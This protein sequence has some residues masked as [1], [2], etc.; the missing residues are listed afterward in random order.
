VEA[1]SAKAIIH[2]PFLRHADSDHNKRSQLGKSLSFVDFARIDFMNVYLRR[3]PSTQNIRAASL[4]LQAVVLNRANNL[5]IRSPASSNTTTSIETLRQR[6]RLN[7]SS[8]NL[9]V[10]PRLA[11]KRWD[12]RSLVASQSHSKRHT[13]LTRAICLETT[14]EYRSKTTSLPSR[15][16]RHKILSRESK[17]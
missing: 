14:K 16:A 8:G 13:R 1:V 5:G 6:R 11:E 17:A 2:V 9:P 12:P 4:R 3:P 15:L 10:Q 7:V